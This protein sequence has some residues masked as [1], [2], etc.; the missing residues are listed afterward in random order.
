MK[1][2]DGKLLQLDAGD[3]WK[4]STEHMSSEHKTSGPFQSGLPDTIVIHYTAG[5]TVDGAVGT[6]TNPSVKASAHIVVGYQFASNSETMEKD[7]VI[8]QLVPF[9]LIAWHAG[10]SSY[11]ERSGL[12]KY[13]IGIEIVNPGFL[14]LMEDGKTYQTEYGQK[15]PQEH[16]AK[17]KH[18]NESFDRYWQTYTDEQLKIVEEIC[19][20]LKA[21]FPIKYILGHEEIAPTRKLDPG[22]AY[23]LELLRSRV[24]DLRSNDDHHHHYGTGVV[25]V[26]N[27]NIRSEGSMVAPK[28]ARPLAKDAVVEI[29]EEKD[30]WYR[31]K[32]EI[33]G[34][35]SANYIK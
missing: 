12:N 26:N 13:S 27:L 31:V 4:L 32:T 33:E 7:R 17:L 21:H 18:R 23:P 15:V 6:L 25:S 3:S 14:K 28:V 19:L 11:G 16:V 29:V 10:K 22:P 9:D 35:V 30:G 20:A 8:E 5:T 24:L 2:K 34:W 1:I